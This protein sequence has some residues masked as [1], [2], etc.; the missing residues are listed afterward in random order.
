MRTTRKTLIKSWTFSLLLLPACLLAQTSQEWQPDFVPPTNQTYR[1]PDEALR[2]FIPP[3]VPVEILQLL[4]LELDGIDVTAMVTTEGDYAIYTP[5]QPIAWGKHQLRLIENSEDGDIIERGFWEFE[6]RK[7]ERFREA[8][9]EVNASLEVS[10]RLGDKNLLTSPNKTQ[11]TGSVTLSGSLADGDWRAEALLPLLYNSAS[12]KRKVELSDYLVSWQQKSFKSQLGHHPIAADNLIM[13]G[14]QRRGLSANY[15][16]PDNNTL[17]TGFAMRG[18]Q[19]SGFEHG[20]GLGNSSDR[21]QGGM[22]T[23][24]PIQTDDKT[25]ELSALYL[26][27]EAPDFGVGI[28]G[29]DTATGG[30]AWSIHADSL[31]L[32]NRLRVRG[33]FARTAYDFDG[34]GANGDEDDHAY[35]LLVSFKPWLE[36]IVDE[37]Y[38]DWSFGA[39]YKRLGTFFRSAANPGA[40]A[41]RKMG[42]L[43]SD[44]TWGAWGLRA[45]LAQESDNVEDIATLPRIRTRLGTLSASYNPPG[46][47]DDE[48]RPLLAWYGQPSYSAFGTV[49]EQKTT[50]LASTAPTTSTDILT[51]VAGLTANFG[52]ENW[53]W[54]LGHT[55][56]R[57]FDDSL[58]AGTPSSNDITNNSTSL[59]ASFA[60]SENLTISPQLSWD[61]TEYMDLGYTDQGLLWG[62]GIDATFIPG[63]LTGR[64]NYDMNRSWVS[65]DSSDNKTHQ[66]AA[67][68]TWVAI[69]AMPQRPGL[70]WTLTGDYNDFTDDITSGNDT[71]RYQVF[72]RA[73]IGWSGSY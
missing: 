59:N 70:T 65:D 28:G 37:Q 56:T 51:E 7:S 60:L 30:D 58:L 8:N 34:S 55:W 4:S 1:T 47:Y 46:N 6:V 38:L 19:V 66:I 14:F 49:Q 24:Y 33:E 2:L 31:S 9:L 61:R 71:N 73:Q 42:R 69:Q 5:A 12:E 18:S 68:L 26:N 40:V 54:G 48:G 21:I 32:Q 57:V 35:S 36:K 39:E 72:L 62:V 43:F 64:L 27:G 23:T 45:Q 67:S 11:G 52:Y 53:S 17:L 44:L 3:S 20:L 41:D 16:L 29:G 50:Q 15:T 63:E 13:S 22:V 10:Q 25:V